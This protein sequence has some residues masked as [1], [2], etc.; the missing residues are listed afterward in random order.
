M[1]SALPPWD[2]DATETDWSANDR[3][4]S[5][6]LSDGA[7]LAQARRSGSGLAALGVGPAV[8]VGVR[9]VGGLLVGAAVEGAIGASPHAGA[10]QD[11]RAGQ[12]AETDRRQAHQAGRDRPHRRASSA[13]RS[14]PRT[15]VRAR[16]IRSL[17]VVSG[18]S[19]ASAIS[20]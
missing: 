7:R 17:T 11:V 5:R 18:R 10:G 6:S 13:G 4:E 1:R 15:K 16:W 9:V 2:T 8:G 3:T 20:S 14:R 12:A 19:T